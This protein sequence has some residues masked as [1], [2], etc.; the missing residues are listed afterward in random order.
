MVGYKIDNNLHPSLMRTFH[1][2]LELTH[3]VLDIIRQIRIYIIVIFYSIWRSG[4][5]FYYGRMVFPDA[6]H[7][8]IGFCSVLYHPCIPYMSNT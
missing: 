6:K 8:V 2:I 5:T 7:G 1:Q 3:T 4:L